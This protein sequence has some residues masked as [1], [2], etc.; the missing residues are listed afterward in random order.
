MTFL[1]LLACA[2]TPADTAPAGGGTITGS[3][4][5]RPFEE[6][7]ASYRIGQPDDPDRTMVVY[8]FD[9]PI[10]CADIVDPGWDA[11]I[12]DQTQAV[13][14]KV[15]GTT[16]GSYPLTSSRTPGPG[17]ADANYTLSS[18]QGTPAETRAD[19]GLSEVDD[20]RAGAASGT[21]SLTF[22]AG[23]V[24]TGTFDAAACDPGSE[25]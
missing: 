22:P 19:S 4:G 24:L 2:N 9:Q 21:F 23:D 18:T 15:V 1:F 13:E 20:A 8:L 16:A 25:P 14:I 12:I 11:H 6:V 17:E 10:A 5:G 7:A 3:F